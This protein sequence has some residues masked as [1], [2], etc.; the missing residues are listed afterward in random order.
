MNGYAVVALD[1]T[2]DAM[3]SHRAID[4]RKIAVE[5]AIPFLEWCRSRKIPIIFSSGLRR[6]TD[7]WFWN[8][9]WQRHCI[10]GSAGLEPYEP[11]YRQGDIV[12]YKRRYSNFFDTELNITLRELGVTSLI[13]IGWSTSVAVLLTAIDAWQL[14]YGV[15]VPKDLTV[16]HA[17][18]GY[19]VEEQQK[20]ALAYIETFAIG[21]ITTSN[22]I[23]NTS[24]LDDFE[25]GVYPN[26]QD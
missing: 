19:T 26:E 12:I 7:K 25:P 24:L 10:D 4:E 13:L 8:A 6:E 23:M 14:F 18:G 16:A 15:L 9:G 17:W 1:M 2:R 21:K 3:E 5:R 11:L 22:E 20:W